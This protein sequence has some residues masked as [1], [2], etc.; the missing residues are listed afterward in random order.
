M[1]RQGEKTLKFFN[2]PGTHSADWSLKTPAHYE[3][4]SGGKSKEN[5]QYRLKD[6][7]EIIKVSESNTQQQL[8]SSVRVCVR[9]CVCARARVCV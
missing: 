3:A 4:E 5:R 1:L 2:A 9:V 6:L 7:D 8:G